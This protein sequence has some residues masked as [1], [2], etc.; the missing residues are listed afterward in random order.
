VLL[1]TPST[2]TPLRDHW[3]W[4]PDWALDRPCL[5]WYLTFEHQPE[6]SQR[7]AAAHERL[8]GVATVDPVPLPWLH[9]TVDDVGFVDALSPDQVDETVASARSAVAGWRPP[10]LT[11]GPVAPMEDSV[12]LPVGPPGELHE[13]RDRLRTATT[14]TLGA[15]A[16]DALGVFRP[17]VTLGY[18]NERCDASTVMRPLESVTADPVVVSVPRV[19][20]ASV[21]RRER[22][23]QWTVR[24]EVPLAG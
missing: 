17:H 9:L 14:T 13:L 21:T 5:L 6:L 11:L 24:G 23:Y 18:L 1:A 22:H 15:T 8:R 3:Q 16:N 7:A 19:T 4:R 20:L 2:S 10:P 12:V